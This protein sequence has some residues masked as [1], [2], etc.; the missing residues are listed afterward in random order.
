MHAFDDFEKENAPSS[1]SS[2]SPERKKTK[3]NDL[4]Q[5][6]FSSFSDRRLGDKVISSYKTS[7]RE[8][9]TESSG[10]HLPDYKRQMKSNLLKRLQQD[11][12]QFQQKIYEEYETDFLTK[13]DIDHEV[14]KTF[15]AVQ[16]SSPLKLGYIKLENVMR[17]AKHRCLTERRLLKSSILPDCP[18]DEEIRLF[19]SHFNTERSHIEDL[20]QKRIT[21]NPLTYR[22][23]KGQLRIPIQTQ[24]EVMNFFHENS[25]FAPRR[26]GIITKKATR[27]PNLASRIFLR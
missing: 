25:C 2:Y 8:T 11:L 18:S 9:T 20:V 26:N 6:S 10:F 1:K 4:S 13:S 3:I 23:D 16:S 24:I 14:T 15:F 12:Q 5:H 17:F 19:A 27:I 7:T 22:C 21:N